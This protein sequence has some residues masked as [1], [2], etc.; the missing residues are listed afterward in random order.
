MAASEA[1]KARLAWLGPVMGLVA[2]AS[3]YGT[4]A[5][6][7]LLSVVG[8]TV[9]IDEG[10]MVKLVSGMLLLVLF[11]MGYSF[12]LHR[13]PGPLVL[14][15]IA[16]AMLLWAFFID[17]SRYLEFAGFGLLTIASIWD[18]RAKKRACAAHCGEAED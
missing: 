14:T 13:Q 6:V 2:V 18:F 16:A 12:K 1:D 15:V 3:C 7:A 5:T 8:V 9:E 4:L 17:Y 11:G 10:L